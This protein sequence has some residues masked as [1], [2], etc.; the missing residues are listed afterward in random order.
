M[1][2]KV[3]SYL[4]GIVLICMLVVMST[5]YYDLLNTREKLDI[6]TISLNESDNKINNL[7]KII[8]NISNTRKIKKDKVKVINEPKTIS[9]SNNNLLNIKSLKNGKWKGQI[10]TDKFGHAIFETK[11]YGIRAASYVLK[12][13]S[14]KH[15]VCTIEGVIDRFC[16]GNKEEYITFLCKNLKVKRDEEIV[17]IK[18]IPKLLRYMAIFESGDHNLPDKLFAGYDVIADL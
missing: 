11:E 16:T 13:Y 7:N 18:Y 8:T 3:F 6:T 1:F 17:L 4:S 12:N 14:K 15:K 5:I 10:G 2:Y 9:E